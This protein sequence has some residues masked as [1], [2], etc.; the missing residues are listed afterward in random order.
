MGPS[1]MF[2]FKGAN[3]ANSARYVVGRQ[4]LNA[5]TGEREDHSEGKVVANVQ[6]QFFSICLI[7]SSRRSGRVQ[8][9][10]P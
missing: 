8:T 5:S 2:V 6:R 1:T 9:Y 10:N 3:S 4:R 7:A